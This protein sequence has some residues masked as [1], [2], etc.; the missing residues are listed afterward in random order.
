[1]DNARLRENQ[2][3]R[4]GWLIGF[5]TATVVLLGALIPFLRVTNT[6]S[7]DPVDRLQNTIAPPTTTSSELTG[8][9]RTQTGEPPPVSL[10]IDH[11]WPALPQDETPSELA[12]AFATNVLGWQ[13]IEDVWALPHPDD[14]TWVR[15]RRADSAALVDVLTM[16][17]D[18]KHVVVEAGHGVNLGPSEVD[19]VKIGLAMVP[20]AREGEIIVRMADGS[21][22]VETVTFDPANP[23]PVDAKLPQV[24]PSSIRSVLIRYRD[25]TGQVI[26]V[27]GTSIP[28]IGEIVSPDERRDIYLADGEQLLAT[29]PTV[30]IGAQSPEPRFDTSELGEEVTLDPIM[31]VSRIIG[32]AADTAYPDAEM[33][34]VTV[35]GTTPQGIEALVVYTIHDSEQERFTLVG[36]N[37]SGISVPL[38][39]LTDAPYGLAPRIPYDQIGPSISSARESHSVV[40][41]DVPPDTSVVVMNIEGET[42]WQRPTDATVIFELK[43]PASDVELT[44]LDSTGQVLRSTHIRDPDRDNHQGR[45]TVIRR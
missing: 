4:R 25:E 9:S 8:T 31:D 20:R 33:I 19:S 1:M 10:G 32:R 5:S 26:R 39:D 7:P 45:S 29:Q 35:L 24:E 28:Q 40:Q 14:V 42:K 12:E 13:A 27:N 11:L 21:F 34:K 16:P 18:G 22:L 43:G 3:K 37:S 44:A 36:D 23:A 2:K 6:N 30:V 38:D 15:I 17:L 41:W